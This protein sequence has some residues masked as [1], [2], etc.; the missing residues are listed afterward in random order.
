MTI[1][2]DDGPISNVVNAANFAANMKALAGV[3]FTGVL[4]SEEDIS[5]AIRSDPVMRVIFDGDTAQIVADEDEFSTEIEIARS[6]LEDQGFTVE[7]FKPEGRPLRAAVET[8]APEPAVVI[9]EVGDEVL[10]AEDAD[11]KVRGWDYADKETIDNS[12]PNPPDPDQV[13]RSSNVFVR[14]WR[15]FVHLFN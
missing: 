1:V 8:E 11:G 4:A 5:V 2:E 12:P 9:P 15:W 13:E 14:V 3:T 10:V 6:Y 7:L